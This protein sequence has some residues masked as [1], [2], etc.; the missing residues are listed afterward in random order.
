MPSLADGLNSP[1][2]GAI[3]V[4]LSG[5][6]PPLNANF[7]GSVIVLIISGGITISGKSYLIGRI[8]G[9]RWA[10]AA[11]VTALA[12]ESTGLIVW[13]ALEP[14]GTVCMGVDHVLAARAG[15]FAC[16]GIGVRRSRSCTAPKSAAP[17]LVVI[18]FDADGIAVVETADGVAVSVAVLAV[19]TPGAISSGLVKRNDS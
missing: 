11:L 17:A 15:L 6:I 3:L 12:G 2:G 13:T 19:L 8:I 18:V 16:S 10:V 4:A 5:G 14:A 7:T 9:S 1:V